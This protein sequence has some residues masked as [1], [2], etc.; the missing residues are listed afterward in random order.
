MQL[1]AAVSPKCNEILIFWIRLIHFHSNLTTKWSLFFELLS[2]QKTK[3]K[4]SF[5]VSL[6]KP[7]ICLCPRRWTPDWGLILHLMLSY[8]AGEG[9][10]RLFNLLCVSQKLCNGMSSNFP[11][12]DLKRNPKMI[13]KDLLPSMGMS[14]TLMNIR[15]YFLNVCQCV[16]AL[17][18]RYLDKAFF[19][20]PI[21]KWLSFEGVFIKCYCQQ[22]LKK[23]K[24]WWGFFSLNCSTLDMKSNSQYDVKG[25]TL[26]FIYLFI[27]LFTVFRNCTTFYY[28]NYN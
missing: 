16:L 9:L 15:G 24:D 11:H 19:L 23:M 4:L 10:S 6:R 7:G 21:C 25:L 1:S 13:I 18:Q 26:L 12:K 20:V 28:H 8:G 5:D 17:V 2:R 22:F 27:Y 14:Y 3:W